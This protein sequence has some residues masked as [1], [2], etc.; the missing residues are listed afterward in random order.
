MGSGNAK[1]DVIQFYKGMFPSV[2]FPLEVLEILWSDSVF[3]VQGGLY[4]AGQAGAS[5]GGVF[6]TGGLAGGEG[7]S[8]ENVQV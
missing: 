4:T 8:E 7:V 3:C 2:V 5:H 6:W 1:P